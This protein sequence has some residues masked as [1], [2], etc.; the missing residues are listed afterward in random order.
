[1][2]NARFKSLIC[3]SAAHRN[4]ANYE[5]PEVSRTFCQPDTEAINKERSQIKK[6][7]FAQ[8]IVASSLNRKDNDVRPDDSISNYSRKKTF[9]FEISDSKIEKTRR[10]KK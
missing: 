6:N 5:E 1:M 10:P 4:D 3:E 7:E 8:S 9:I 2:E